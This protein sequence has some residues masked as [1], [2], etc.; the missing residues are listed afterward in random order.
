M[1]KVIDNLVPKSLADQLE[2]GFTHDDTEW[3]LQK[4]CGGDYGVQFTGDQIKDTHQMYHSLVSDDQPKSTLTSL[5]LCVMF[6]LDEKFGIFP[7][8]L[9]R[10]KA[11]LLFPLI[12]GQGTYHPPHRDKEFDNYMSLVYY[13]NDSDGPT[14]FFDM[15]GNVIQEVLP[16]KGRAVLFPSTFIHAS[17]CPT[18]FDKRIVINY[19]FQVS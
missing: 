6:F 16:K 7:K 5:S 1:I 12:D 18:N 9:S 4:G 3:N 10:V 8:E 11:N 2:E 13:V 14:R 19:V 15:N 17:S